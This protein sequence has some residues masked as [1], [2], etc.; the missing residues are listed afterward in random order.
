VTFNTSTGVLSGTPASGTAGTYPITF[1]ASNSVGSNA[2]QRLTLTVNA[3]SSGSTLKISP[4][5]LNFGTVYAGTTTLQETTLTNTG[6]TMITFTNF[7]VM[8]ISGDDS[9]GFLGIELCPRTLNAGK[10]CVVVMSFTADSNVTKIHAAS[11]LIT[12]N[13]LGSPQTVP[14]SATVINPQAYLSTTNLSFGNQKT[15][16]TSAAKKVTLTNSGTTPLTLSGLSVAGNFAIASGGCTSTITLAPGANCAINVTFTPAT[17][18]QKSGSV[19]ITDNAQ[20]SPQYVSLSG[21][22]D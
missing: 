17:R 11:L 18:G 13:A 15:G 22:G 5:T 21:I 20:N 1:T 4:A 19:K 2:T 7:N 3:G 9:S 12:N 16:T 6:S 14:M 10:S 8:P